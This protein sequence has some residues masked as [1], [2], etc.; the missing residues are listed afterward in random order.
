MFPKRLKESK[1][2]Q[3]FVTQ[4]EYAVLAEN[5]TAPWLRTFVALGF[6]FGF[7]KGEMLALRVRNVDLLDGWLVIETS[8]NGEGR[9]VKLTRETQA[10]LVECV[11]GKNLDDFVLTR[12]DGSRVAQP[13]KD[14]YSLCVACGLGKKADREARRWQDVYPLRRSPDARSSAVGGET[15]CAVWS[16]GEDLH[17]NQWSQDAQRFR[18][19]QHH[20]RARSRAGCQATGIRPNVGGFR[21]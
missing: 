4:K 21:R 1:P 19:L 20:Q 8:K 18:S 16:A 3:G 12:P 11:R 14:W 2:R 5:A 15:P 10:L 6:N 13:R 7:R 9:K 17:G